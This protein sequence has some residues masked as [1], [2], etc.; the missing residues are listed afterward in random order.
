MAAAGHSASP[1]P[2]LIG[3]EV[4]RYITPVTRAA[5]QAPQAAVVRHGPLLGVKATGWSSLLPD[6]DDRRRSR[7]GLICQK[8][9]APVH[10]IQF[11]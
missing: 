1:T 11:V 4:D 3:F 9:L 6:C 5:T 7:E 2:P 10:S 8:S